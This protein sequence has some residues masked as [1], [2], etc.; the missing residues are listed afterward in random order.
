MRLAQRLLLG[1]A[2]LVSVLVVVLVTLLDSRLRSRL[3]DDSIHALEREA[4][5]VAAE[6]RPGMDADSLADAASVAVGHRVTIVDSTGRVI[7][8]SDFDPPALWQLENHGHRPE[9]VA[10]RAAGHGSARRVSH[11]V[12]TEELYVA[13]RA[14]IGA[15]RL[16]VSTQSIDELFEGT[17]RD[18]LVTGLLALLGSLGLA[19]LFSRA[20]SRPVVELRDVARAI[21]QGDLSRRPALSA[22]GEVGDLAS[23]IHRMGEQLGARLSALQKDETLLTALLASLNE[24]VIVLDARRQVVRVNDY[25]RSLLRLRAR[26][27]F[28]LDELPR[29]RALREAIEDALA[30]ASTD[31]VEMTVLDRALVLTARPLA[32]GG[33]I[34][35]FYD[36]TPVRRLE[37]VRRDFVANVSHELRTPLTVI[38]G[39]AETL[40]H[41]EPPPEMRRQFVSSILSH[42][43]RMQRIVDDLL[44][45]SRIESGGWV[46]APV[47]V[48]VAELAAEATA[49]CRAAAVEKG[50]ELE[51]ALDPAARHV[52]ADPTALRQVISNLVNNAVR[53]TSRGAVTVFTRAARGGAWIGVRD[54]G[55][56]IPAEHLPRIFERFYRVDAGRSREQGGTGLGLAIVRHLV[57]AHRGRVTAESTVGRGTT[58]SAFF[59]APDAPTPL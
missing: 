9:I 2:L 37:A 8:D 50:I 33:A 4:R 38:G 29:E 46:P 40:E 14:P 43:R 22:P 25:A 54:T 34:V 51:V 17:R 56:G 1:A 58:I 31:G 32:D 6:W 5:L 47:S 27:P 44:D 52:W 13:V 21:A 48:D 57:E 26:T 15:V 41:D 23:A 11:S 30:G 35:A 45:L 59:P 3:V 36:L 55:S 39:Y 10:A 20:V 19:W 18:V 28:A 7:G 49:S 42:T 12:G 16:A 24:G 53:H